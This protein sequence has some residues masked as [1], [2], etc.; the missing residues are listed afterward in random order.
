MKFVIITMLACVTLFSQDLVAKNVI[1]GVYSDMRLIPEESDYLGT[2][3]TLLESRKDGVLQYH[4]LIQFAQG[5]PTPPQLV[6]VSV[7][8]MNIEFI[9]N[10]MGMMNVKFVGY[11][12]EDSLKG[13]FS[14][15][16]E[17]VLPRGNSIWQSDPK[18]D[19][20]ISNETERCLEENYTT[21]GM[22]VCLDK[23]HKAWDGELNRFYRELRSKLGKKARRALRSAQRKWIEQR[24]L[25]FALIDAIFSEPEFEGTM[26]DPIILENKNE[27][28]RKRADTLSEYLKEME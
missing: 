13:S 9:V 2:E 20:V 1:T 11:V 22:I 19:D 8:G 14:Q 15:L 26:W 21:A 23:E 3:V 28:I 6:S 4:A 16:G 25:E 10:Y 17:V 24:N 5:E 12:T 7:K 27:V 18:T